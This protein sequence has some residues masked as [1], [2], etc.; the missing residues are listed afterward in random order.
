MGYFTQGVTD[1]MRQTNRDRLF[2]VTRDD[3]IHVT[4]TWVS[5]TTEFRDKRPPPRNNAFPEVAA[6]WRYLLDYNKELY[7]IWRNVSS[8]KNEK[9]DHYFRP[10]L[11]TLGTFSFMQSAL[12]MW[13]V[14]NT[15]KRHCWLHVT[16]PLDLKRPSERSYA[17]CLLNL[18]V[19]TGAV[20]FGILRYFDSFPLWALFLMATCAFCLDT[21]PPKTF[22]TP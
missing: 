19:V 2:S 8:W 10:S 1:D 17:L 4:R 18:R 11:P 16:R 14:S 9:F 13:V 5:S 20:T 22:P 21:W 7:C 15:H 3:I 6:L 12:F